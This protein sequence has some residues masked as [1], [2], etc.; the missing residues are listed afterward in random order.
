MP[1][2]N[3]KFVRERVGSGKDAKRAAQADELFAK[4]TQPPHEDDAQALQQL[5]D[6]S[7]VG[8]P[9]EG[10]ATMD[11][12][13]YGRMLLNQIGGR[14]SYGE[15]HDG[16]GFMGSVGG[17]LKKLAPAAALIPGIGPLAAGGIAALANTGGSLLKGE[18]LDIT[19][20]LT[21]GLLGGAG[22]A[23][24]QGQGAGGL[25]NLVKHGNVQ[26]IQAGPSAE[27]LGEAAKA[28]GMP[29]PAAPAAAAPGGALAKLGGLG[30]VAKIGMGAAALKGMHDS[31]KASEQ[32]ANAQ[33]QLRN[34]QLGM[35]EQDYASRAP[36]RNTAFQRLGQMASGPMGSS[37]YR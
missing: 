36:L 21:D 25:M 24:L 30:G 35:A 7:G 29:A 27:A 16:G 19:G 18:G 10:W 14:H 5:T 4:A 2:Y 3:E 22:S 13:N 20:S 34:R 32:M 28:A 11:A 8:D 1:Q 17:A 23:L 12:K 31:R 15:A 33:L 37:V 26:G 9:N 6:L